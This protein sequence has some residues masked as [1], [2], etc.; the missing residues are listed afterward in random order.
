MLWSGQA[1]DR[2][3]IKRQ[4]GSK[5]RQQT[6]VRIVK[7]VQVINRETHLGVNA[8]KCLTECSCVISANEWLVTAVWLVQWWMGNA[9]CGWCAAVVWY[10][11]QC[12][13]WAWAHEPDS[14]QNH[15]IFTSWEALM[16]NDSWNAISSALQSKFTKSENPYGPGYVIQM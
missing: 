12:G 7:T 13:E 14:W 5:G 4:A 16:T 9:V 6:V 1:A 2:E 10:K 8:R 15:V 11:R 3:D